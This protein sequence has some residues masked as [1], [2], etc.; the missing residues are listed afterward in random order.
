MTLKTTSVDHQTCCSIILFPFHLSDESSLNLFCSILCMPW[1]VALAIVYHPLTCSHSFSIF[2]NM[3]QSSDLRMPLSFSVS[4]Q[5][6]YFSTSLLSL[7]EIFKKGDTN[8]NC[9][10]SWTRYHINYIHSYLSDNRTPF[11]FLDYRHP[12]ICPKGKSFL[13][14]LRKLV[15]QL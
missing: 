12:E 5:I 4:L 11:V 10:S 1:A 13:Y 7:G 9:L 3:Y 15:S 6:Y 14:Q 8:G 2:Q